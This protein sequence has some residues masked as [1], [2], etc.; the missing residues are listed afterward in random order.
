MNLIVGETLHDFLCLGSVHGFFD[1]E[2][3]ADSWRT[4]LFERYANPPSSDDEEAEFKA[5]FRAEFSLSPWREIEPR[6]LQL[7][8]KYKP[9]LQFEAPP[10]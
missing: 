5:K 8:A 3:L 2:K 10:Q 7:D 4:E 6:L 9:M 1:L